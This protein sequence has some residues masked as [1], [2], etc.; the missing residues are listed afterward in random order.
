MKRKTNSP[1][2]KQKTM[3]GL[4]SQFDLILSKIESLKHKWDFV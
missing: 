4:N 1:K 3:K 2:L